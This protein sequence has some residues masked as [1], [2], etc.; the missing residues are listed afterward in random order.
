M[1]AEERQ[2]VYLSLPTTDSLNQFLGIPQ[3]KIVNFPV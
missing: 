3:L 1:E 2:E